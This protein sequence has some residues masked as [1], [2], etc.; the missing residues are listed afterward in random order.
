MH[1]TYAVDIIREMPPGLSKLYDHIMARIEKGMRRDPQYYKDILATATLALRPLALPELAALAGL[2]HGMDPRTIVKK[3]GSFLT[4]EQDTVYL[5]HQSAKDYLDEN[6]TTRLQPA[7]VAQGHAD[8][9]KR[10]IEAMA[11]DLRQNM[12]NLDFGFKLDDMT[13]PISLF[14]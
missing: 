12:Y 1:G 7:G 13:P 3:C 14:K 4:A 9:D 5:I 2:P 11:S 10:S 6:Y 8:I